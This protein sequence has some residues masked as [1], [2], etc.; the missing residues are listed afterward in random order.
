M[1]N[2]RSLYTALA[3]AD[4]SYTNEAGGTTT[5]ACHDLHQ[6]KQQYTRGELPIRVLLP[7]EEMPSGGSSQSQ[8]VTASAN[9]SAGM[10]ALLWTV[11]DLY[12]HRVATDGGN[13]LQDI[14]PDLLRYADQYASVVAAGLTGTADCLTMQAIT[15]SAGVYEYP[16]ASGAFFHGVSVQHQWLEVY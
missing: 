11:T 9:G 16:Q 5:V 15:F 3:A 6:V 12:L 4:M 14:M 2:I 10:L 1:S 7:L 8:M 13:L